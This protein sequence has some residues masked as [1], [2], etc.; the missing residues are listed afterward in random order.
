MLGVGVGTLSRS[1]CWD[2]EL[3][4]KLESILMSRLCTF[5]LPYAVMLLAYEALHARKAL[6]CKKGC[7][8]HAR[9][10]L[11]W[12]H[13]M[14]YFHQRLYTIGSTPNNLHQRY[15]LLYK[16]GFTLH[17]R[18]EIQHDTIASTSN[19]KG[20]ATWLLCL[21]RDIAWQQTLHSHI[22]VLQPSAQHWPSI[23]ILYEKWQ[24]IYKKHFVRWKPMGIAN[25]FATIINPT[26][27]FL[28][29]D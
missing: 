17:A 11:L 20:M 14:L 6:L 27:N 22:N 21:C 2:S 18:L 5:V 8:L 13:T 16:Q 28:L 12:M 26:I 23:D 29:Q 19:Q 25:M 3:E 7:T 9:K 1:W 10:T 4:S 15:A 24:Q